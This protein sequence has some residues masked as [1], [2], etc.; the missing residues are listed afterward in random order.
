[1]GQI[2]AQAHDAARVRHRAGVEQYGATDLQR[3]LGRQRHRYLTA[4]ALPQ[5]QYA[6]D[7]KRRQDIGHVLGVAERAVVGGSGPVVCPTAAGQVDED[8]RP[9]SAP[10]PLEVIGKGGKVA[11]VAVVAGKAH[12]RHPALSEIAAQ[13]HRGPGARIAQGD[14]RHRQAC[15]GGMVVGGNAPARKQRFHAPIYRPLAASHKAFRVPCGG[16]P[17]KVRCGPIGA[18]RHRTL[19]T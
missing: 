10:Q 16:P 15:E 3:V 17:L 14:M 8:H 6:A 11:H 2:V 13:M 1:M 7:S 18:N 12:K 19:H 9:F 5:H 4:M